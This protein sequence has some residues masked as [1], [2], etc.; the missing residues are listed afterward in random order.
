ME[1][2]PPVRVPEPPVIQAIAKP[3]T[4]RPYILPAPLTGRGLAV[5][6]SHMESRFVDDEYEALLELREQSRRRRVAAAALAA[7]LPPVPPPPKRKLG[8]GY[9]N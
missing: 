2:S 9:S 5:S 3:P 8:A 4:T 6:P 1:P 7:E